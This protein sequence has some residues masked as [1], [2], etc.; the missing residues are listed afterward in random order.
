MT[1]QLSYAQRLE[2]RLDVLIAW[3]IADQ[4]HTVSRL[5]TRD[6]SELR[7][8]FLTLAKSGKKNSSTT[9]EAPEP[10]DGGPQYINDN[11]AP[12]P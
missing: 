9:A 2:Q 3:A 7:E 6:F 11:P 8:A 1:E 10:A 12:W 4:P 5:S